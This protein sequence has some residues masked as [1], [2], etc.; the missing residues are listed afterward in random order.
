M[1]ND[2]PLEVWLQIIP[3]ISPSDIHKLVGV[4]RVLF[5]YVMDDIY[6]KVMFIP[7]DHSE[8]NLKTLLQIRCVFCW[9]R[10]SG[11]GVDASKQPTQY[12]LSY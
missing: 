5:E 11:S 4:S 1:A 12:Y 7:S 10:H 2:L 6:R 9:F 8:A 3:L